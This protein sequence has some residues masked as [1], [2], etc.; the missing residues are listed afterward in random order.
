MALANPFKSA[1]TNALENVMY[2][3]EQCCAYPD[4]LE[5]LLKLKDL[6]K[7]FL[8]K[9]QTDQIALSYMSPIHSAPTEIFYPELFGPALGILVPGMEQTTAF[10]ETLDLAQDCVLP[11]PWNP[12]SMKA[13]IGIYGLGY[14]RRPWIQQHNNH[15]VLWCPTFGIG[16]VR[17][18][19]HSLTAA[20]IT[21]ELTHFTIKDSC[22]LSQ[23][24]DTYFFDGRAFRDKGSQKFVSVPEVKEFGIVYELSRMIHNLQNCGDSAS[25]SI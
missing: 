11:T 19:N 22:D 8:R 16:I 10:K 5:A 1:S 24:F 15:N 14:G 20:V 9:I 23:M 25:G 21:N 18:G 17:G 6:R 12:S 2:F 13:N 7:I 4:A 3:A